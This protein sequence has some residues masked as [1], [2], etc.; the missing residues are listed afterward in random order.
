MTVT[1]TSEVFAVEEVL[2]QKYA[3]NY[4]EYECS[5]NNN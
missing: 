5:D 3:S 2:N 1:A 4:V